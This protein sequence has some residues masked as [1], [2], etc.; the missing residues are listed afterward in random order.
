MKNQE[1]FLMNIYE[2]SNT[3]LFARSMAMMDPIKIYQELNIPLLILD[4]V[5]EE[6]LFPFEEENR[7]LK[8]MHPDLI[9]HHIYENTGHNIHYEKPDLF[10]RDVL[11]FLKSFNK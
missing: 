7:A 1:Q 10:I 9:T 6:D 2:P 8:K 11:S 3:P 5:N 4:P